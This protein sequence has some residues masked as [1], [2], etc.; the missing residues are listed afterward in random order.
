MVLR[1]FQEENIERS[2]AIT[3]REVNLDE[4][5]AAFTLAVDGYVALSNHDVCFEAGLRTA[6]HPELEVRQL[7]VH[8]IQG[9]VAELGLGV[10]VFEAMP[11]SF[12]D[13]CVGLIDRPRVDAGRIVVVD[14]GA[15]N[16]QLLHRLLRGVDRM[17]AKG[18]EL[19]VIEL[20]REA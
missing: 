1:L 20:K 8:L 4:A 3:K 5:L 11:V 6:A 2:P 19:H 10:A 15:V 13:R 17:P 9:M 7:P 12:E 18:Q 16:E 14:L